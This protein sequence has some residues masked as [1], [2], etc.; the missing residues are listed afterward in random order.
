MILVEVTN[1]SPLRP[2][3]SM[4]D[5]CHQT[6]HALDLWVVGRAVGIGARL[7]VTGDG[8][9]DDARIDHGYVVISQPQPAHRP[10]GQVLQDNVGLAGHVEEHLPSFGVSQVQGHALHPLGAFQEP[11]GNILFCLGGVVDALR[12]CKWPVAPDWVSAPRYLHLDDLGSQTCQVHAE[13]RVRQEYRHGEH[14]D[15]AQWLHRKYHAFSRLG[16]CQP[17]YTPTLPG[18]HSGPEWGGAS[19]VAT[20]ERDC[21]PVRSR[22][23]AYVAIPPSS[24]HIQVPFWTWLVTANIVLSNTDYNVVGTRPIRPDGANKV[25]GRAKYG[26]D[27]QM[28]GLLHGQVLRS[29]HAHACIKSI[30]TRKAE[31]HPGVKPVVTARSLSEKKCSKR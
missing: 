6:A 13:V 16:D 12:P 18:A 2:L 20:P 21:L 29:P 5:N 31:A 3:A 8:A 7:A 23:E 17:Q 15:I 19:G 22:S 14:S 25:T 10:G 4:H 11:G 26:G 1:N 27:F 30:D 9:V 24:A 28:S